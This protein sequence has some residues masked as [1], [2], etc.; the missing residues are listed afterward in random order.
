MTLYYSRKTGKLKRIYYSGS[1]LESIYSNSNSDTMDLEDVYDSKAM[2]LSFMYILGN[3]DNIQLNQ[4]VEDVNN[5]SKIEKDLSYRTNVTKEYDE[6]FNNGKVDEKFNDR[7]TYSLNNDKY[8][9][10]YT[11]W[12]SSSSYSTSGIISFSINLI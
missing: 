9:I 6:L 11:T 2:L 1:I 12:I 4:D 7:Y 3:K 8:D 10:Q 5:Y